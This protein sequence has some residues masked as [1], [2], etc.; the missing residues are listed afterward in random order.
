MQLEALKATIRDVPDFPSKGIVFRDLTTMI[1][2]GEALKVMSHAMSE[3]YR[4]KSSG[5]R[6]SRVYRRQYPRL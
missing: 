1:K 4:D 6:K 3:L 5:Y 2:N